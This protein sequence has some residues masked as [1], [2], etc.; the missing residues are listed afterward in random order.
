MRQYYDGGLRDRVDGLRM[1]LQQYGQWRP[2][3]DVKQK[4]EYPETPDDLWS[5]YS[6]IRNIGVGM[7]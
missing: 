2:R 1:S 3:D 4:L 7:E 5:V 6:Y